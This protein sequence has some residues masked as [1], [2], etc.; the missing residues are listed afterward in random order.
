[1]ENFNS[2]LDRARARLT[3]NPATAALAQR[4]SEA[5]AAFGGAAASS[6][7]AI[8]SSTAGFAAAQDAARGGAAQVPLSK[9]GVWSN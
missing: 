2:L 1:M 8:R 5:L 3:Q 9:L 4:L 7:A 6:L